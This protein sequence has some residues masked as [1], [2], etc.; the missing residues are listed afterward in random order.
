MGPG[1]VR[2]DDWPSL[3]AAAFEVAARTPFAWGQHDCVLFAGN[4]VEAITSIDPFAAYRNRYTTPAGAL[5][6]IK[7]GCPSGTLREMVARELGP[8]V[9]PLAA[10]RGDVAL[11]DCDPQAGFSEAL[12]ICDGD[13]VIGLAPHG[14]LCEANIAS[15]ICAWRIG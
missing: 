11:I 15:A 9:V 4:I 13:R 12:G 8:E 1:L 14:G 2:L 7:R 6:I 5:R 3:M 10:R